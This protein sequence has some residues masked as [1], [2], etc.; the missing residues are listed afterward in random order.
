MSG[1]MAI[2]G[3]IPIRHEPGYR[4]ETIGRY[5]GGQFFASITAAYPPDYRMGPDWLEHRRWYAVLHRFDSAGLHAGSDIWTPGPGVPADGRLDAKLEG[6]LAELPGLEY[7][8]IAI[9][10]FQVV[11]DGIRF[12]LI[13]ERHG[14]GGA[15]GK[16]DKDG[17]TA[18]GDEDAQGGK[19]G[20]DDGEPDWAE[21]Y[22]D[23]LG[24]H[25]PWDGLYDT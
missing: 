7:G 2:P 5:D 13:A 1:A 15:G 25:E 19:S 22:P 9:A 21:L 14:T 12:G 20:E 23:R 24:F 6:W 3:V 8:D 16:S 18:Q 11:V 17:E 4:T 10:P